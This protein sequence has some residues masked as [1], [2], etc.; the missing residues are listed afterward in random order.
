MLDKIF[1]NILI[2]S[3]YEP[4]HHEPEGSGGACSNNDD[5][6]CYED[7]DDTYYYNYYEG[8]GS[9]ENSRI[10]YGYLCRIPQSYMVN[11]AGIVSMYNSDLVF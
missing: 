5:E 2:F 9:G 8:S 10:P 4:V 6:D 3:V 7:S 1:Y 11:R